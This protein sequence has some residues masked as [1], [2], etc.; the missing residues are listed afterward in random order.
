MDPIA[1]G[2]KPMGYPY[3]LNLWFRHTS[4]WR[5]LVNG[6]CSAGP[7]EDLHGARYPRPQTAATPRLLGELGLES[8]ST[9]RS[10]MRPPN[11]LNCVSLTCQVPNLMSFVVAAPLC[12][13]ASC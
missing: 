2:R 13:T 3:T 5:I 4:G 10:T 1:S 12:A 11:M 9:F 6:F 7:R 8:L